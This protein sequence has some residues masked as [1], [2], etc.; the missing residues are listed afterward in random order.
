VSRSLVLL[1][2]LAPL[3]ACSGSSPSTPTSPA[4]A[5]MTVTTPS[6]TPAPGAPT[7]AISS[8]GFSPREITIA[9]GGRVTFVNND[10]RPHDLVGGLDPARPECP[11]IAV[12]GF[13]S[14]GQSRDTGVFTIARECDFHDH[15]AI[16]VP[17][18]QGK[19]VVR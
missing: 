5:N 15:A 11:E 6:P 10:T 1:S 9:V 14:P 4:P 8:A 12:A 17:A 7:I 18:F 19:I 3:T 16:G 2:L 13:L